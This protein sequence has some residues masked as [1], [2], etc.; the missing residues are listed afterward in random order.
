HLRIHSFLSLM[1]DAHR[2]P[3]TRRYLERNR[4]GDLAGLQAWGVMARCRK[5]EASD[6][7]DKALALYGLFSEL[8]MILP[9]PDYTKSVGDIYADTTASCIEYDKSLLILYEVPSDRR[10]PG[11]PSWVPDWSDKGWDHLD[12]RYPKW[13]LPFAASGSSDPKWEF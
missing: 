13:R 10:R 3:S 11:L 6:P 7:K 12:F 4:P 1:M 2:D 8:G 5:R 9:R